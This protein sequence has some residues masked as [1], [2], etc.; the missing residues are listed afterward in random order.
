MNI[1]N[2]KSNS[3]GNDS[4]FFWG[5]HRIPSYPQVYRAAIW[6]PRRRSS[7]RSSVWSSWISPLCTISIATRCCLECFRGRTCLIWFVANRCVFSFRSYLH[8]RSI[9][10][11][12]GYSPCWITALRSLKWDCLIVINSVDQMEKIQIIIS[13]MILSCSQSE[14]SSIDE[15]GHWAW[16]W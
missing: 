15:M 11:C 10:V 13:N 14:G 4:W 1:M 12:H 7:Q 6:W 9:S 2:I 5:S 16:S 3:T 8:S